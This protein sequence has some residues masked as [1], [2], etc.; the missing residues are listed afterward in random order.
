VITWENLYDRQK[1][2]RLSG[3]EQAAYILQLKAKADRMNKKEV[4]R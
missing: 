1:Y 3:D 2:N 4:S